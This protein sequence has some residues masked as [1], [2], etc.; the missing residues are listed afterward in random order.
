MIC[1]IDFSESG[2]KLRPVKTHGIPVGQV[3]QNSGDRCNQPQKAVVTGPGGDFDYGQP[4]VMLETGCK[5]RVSSTDIEDGFRWTMTDVNMGPEE[6]AVAVAEAE[7]KRARATAEAKAEADRKA[8]AKA[9]E[10]EAY[11][12]RFAG[13]LTMEG[14]DHAKG[15][16]NVKRELAKAFPGHK[17]SVK[18]DSLSIRVNWELG[19]TTK[20]IQVYTRKYSKGSFDGMDDS[21]TAWPDIFGGA[22]YVT[23]TRGDGT[24]EER[25]A[26]EAVLKNETEIYK[27]ARSWDIESDARKLILSASYPPGV[28]ITGAER[29]PHDD[30]NTF[31]WPASSYQPTFTV[32]K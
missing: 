24:A 20:E 7:L 16:K 10:G 5:V 11:K 13:F 30:N 4:A 6:M 19:P 8:A 21:Y 1:K 28:V 12:R 22:R 23:E 14:S 29:I 9:E 32:K 2:F 26:V 18:S 25:K 31:D 15:A 3:L 27:D 17:F